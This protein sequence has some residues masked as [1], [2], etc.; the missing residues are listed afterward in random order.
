VATVA[1]GRYSAELVVPSS[2]WRRA[3]VVV[4]TRGDRMIA[5]GRRTIRVRQAS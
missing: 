1:E 4:T 2:R 3:T 5:P